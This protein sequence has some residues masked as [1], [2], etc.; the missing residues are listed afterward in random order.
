MKKFWK[1][2]LLGHFLVD[3][4]LGTAH[5][6]SHKSPLKEV[7][8][9]YH[10]KHHS[11]HSKYLSVKYV[12][13]PFYFEVFLTQI[14]FAFLPRFMGIDVWT[15]IFLVN[16]FSVQLL[17]EHSGCINIFALSQHHEMHHNYGN[18]AFYHFPLVEIFLGRMPSLKQLEK[19]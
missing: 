5:M 13:N 1:E 16:F 6:L 9:K 12:G 18:V 11:R 3:L 4:V 10:A 2:I 17:L 15:G 8:F 7:L 14:C 19:N